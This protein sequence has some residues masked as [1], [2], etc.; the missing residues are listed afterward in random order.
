[1]CV[2][3]ASGWALVGDVDLDLDLGLVFQAGKRAACN[4]RLIHRFLGP[5][6]SCS[7]PPCEGLRRLPV[8]G[9]ISS[10]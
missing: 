8:T 2:S 10:V 1:M 6:H 5:C 7:W 3:E 9:C 4:S